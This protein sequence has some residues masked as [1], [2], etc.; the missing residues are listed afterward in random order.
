MKSGRKMNKLSEEEEESIESFLERSDITY[1]TPGRRDTVYVGMDG[2]KREYKQERYLIQKLRNLLEIINGSKIII[3]ENF[4]SLTEAFE[5]ELS[6][7]QMLNFLKMH[8]EKVYYSYMPLFLS[9]CQV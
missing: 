9:L 6:F 8:K 4:P 7:R 2:D 1:T 5:H 3:N